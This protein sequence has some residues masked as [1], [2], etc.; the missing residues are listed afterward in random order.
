M[1]RREE[2][3]DLALTPYILEHYQRERLFLTHNHPTTFLLI[4]VCT[5]L[6]DVAG[7]PI[8]VDRLRASERKNVADLAY[9]SVDCRISPHDLKE[10]ECTFDRI[11]TGL[12]W[13]P[14]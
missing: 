9:D 14:S 1:A 5:Q 7:L 11:R 3:T 4:E 8:D 13:A 6:R 12:K 10:L 2:T